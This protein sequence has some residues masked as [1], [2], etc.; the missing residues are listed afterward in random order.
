M[1]PTNILLIQYVV[2]NYIFVR[3]NDVFSNSSGGTCLSQNL[4]NNNLNLGLQI[5]PGR[6][7]MSKSGIVR[8]W[9]NYYL[10]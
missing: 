4:K 6:I 5:L 9:L 2:E 10:C 3:K 8:Q 7:Y 1:K